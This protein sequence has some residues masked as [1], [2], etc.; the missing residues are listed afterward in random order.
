MANDE[1]LVTEGS[2]LFS[3]ASG[4]PQW[5]PLC[6]VCGEACGELSELYSVFEVA[7]GSSLSHDVRGTRSFQV[8]VHMVVKNCRRKLMHP[9]PIWAYLLCMLVGIT[10]G[11]LMG[12]IAKPDWPSRMGAFGTFGVI[13]AILAWLPVA[14][15]FRSALAIRELG[16]ADYIAD[17]KDQ[18]CA[19]RFAELNR[20]IVSPIRRPNWDV[21]IS[22]FPK[23]RKPP[24]NL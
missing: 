24:S 1:S 15:V 7:R 23:R 2:V 6:V 19:Q 17:F 21:S 22:L 5:P 10:A 16:G 9:K 8:P 14:V 18:A 20:A 13:A 4:L 11:A 12:Y 3:V